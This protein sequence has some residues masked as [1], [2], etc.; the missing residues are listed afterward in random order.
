LRT[1]VLT[2]L[3][4][5]H[6]LTNLAFGL[7]LVVGFLA[8][9]LLPRQQDPTVNFNFIV[10]TTVL[11][12]AS[13]ADV[14]K[15][16]T[17][18]LEDALR[19][20]Q[21]VK[22]M[23]STS[24]EAVS[25]ILIRF[26]DVEARIFDK[27]LNDLRREIQNAEKDLP[28]EADDPVVLEVT[29]A[30][31]YPAAT[32]AVVG[33]ADD[34][35][36]RVQARNVEKELERFEEID[37]VDAVGLADPEIHVSF[38]P[39][40]LEALGVKP[41]QVADT[42]AAFFR[43]VAAGTLKLG[44]QSWLVRLVGSERDP[45]QLARRSLVGAPGEI[46]L[47]RVAA[48]E[49]GREKP[50]MLARLDGRPAVVLAVLK[51]ENA[52]TLE[53]VDR[54]NRFIAQ[55]NRLAAKTG[56]ELVLVDDQT[57]PTRRAITLMETNAG[58]GLVLVLAVAW[59]FLGS[60]IALFTALGI[61]FSL[62]GTFLTL[63]ALG[64]TLNV[65]VLLGVVIV[66]GMLVDD[67]V[68]VVEAIYYRL[69]RGVSRLDAALDSMRE[70]AAPVTASVLTTMAAF[71]PLMLLPG[72]LGDFM[73]VIPMVVSIA[74]AVSL[75]EAFWMLP[76]HVVR[77]G[78]SF[79]RPSHLQRYRVRLTR[80]VQR[81]YLRALLTTL[82]RPRLSLSV[83]TLLFAAALAAVGSGMVR[84]EFF[85]ADTLRLFYVNVEMP[86]A[87]PL[88]RTLQK[89]LEI[90]KKVRRHA[91][92]GEVR[93]IVSYAGNMFTE[94]EPRV[95]DHYGQILVGLNPKRPGLREV[96]GMIEAMRA[97]VLATPG[98]IQI[99]FL[100]LS[101]GPP[102]ERPISVKVRG[103]RYDEI[104]AAASALKGILQ[105]IPGVTDIE[106]DAA[107]GRPELVLR[108]DED[109]VNRAGLNPL[110]LS[111]SLQL[112]VDGEIVAEM[113]DAGEKVEVR[114]R[115]RPR[116][117]DDLRGL[118]SIR[119]PTPSG[120]PVPLGALVHEVREQG[121]G[122]FRHYNFRRAITVEA[123][124][125]KG[126]TDTLTANRLVREGWAKQ[127]ANFPDIDLDFSGELD[128]I[129]ES[130]D[131]IGILFLFGVG[132][133]Y[134][135][136]G[137]QFRS[138]FQ[139][140]MILATVPMAFTGVVLGLIVTG[141][142]LSLYTLYG[143]VA[144]AGIAVN[145]AIVLISAANDRLAR[146]MSL[147]HATIYAAR[148]RVIPILITSLSTIAGL[149]SLAT[150]LGG[151]SLIWGPVATA[152]VWGLAFSTFLTLFVVPL[153]YRTFKGRGNSNGPGPATTSVG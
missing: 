107:R 43:D 74:L 35:N 96:E 83:I 8:Y 61:P 143:V 145:A 72:I 142:P 98:P 38:D 2:T 23:S 86:P 144:L 56:V 34:E 93:A 108:L 124:L 100:R 55:R 149:F 18:P 109:A 101:G 91:K 31:A 68:V 147:L 82:R 138:Y 22:F 6:V 39:S 81:R 25:T 58:I 5:N 28:A 7:V 14:E 50:T 84:M 122:N 63:F 27:R 60:R 116:D 36:L 67:A 30:N 78:P 106:D 13:A 62:A 49:R 20:V 10:V 151:R 135:I 41:T 95:G 125:A 75:V 136:L 94:M 46:T 47:G 129:Q 121:I 44:G 132:L 113:R 29:S 88:E 85:A 65:T 45:G 97:D 119:L 1:G 73:R 9:A 53:L 69:Q 77:A 103:D 3:L 110:E 52:N 152:I 140:L 134:L 71:V 54:I 104:R 70:V 51:Q 141:N 33:Q 146:G 117:Q 115:A 130:L 127:Q 112:L 66:L 59:V 92:P 15:K 111:R 24:R 120:R 139:P 105:G 57:I 76:A 118:L 64:E 42:V 32:V 80:W 126:G 48:V 133:M 19:L 153:L 4:R 90:E 114:V 11:P 26:E 131:S 148:R 102:T 99:S 37:R 89:V 12:G 137:T 150:G 87:T 79:A 16:V 123:S 21:N 17:D 128:D 40:A